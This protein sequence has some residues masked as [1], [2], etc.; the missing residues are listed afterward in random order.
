MKQSCPIDIP[1]NPISGVPINNN[2][3]NNISIDS[4]IINI[5][6]INITNCLSCDPSL[7]AVSLP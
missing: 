6:N 5:N 2:N 3:N 7:F 4:I 1:D